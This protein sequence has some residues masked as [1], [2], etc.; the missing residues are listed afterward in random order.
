MENPKYA[1]VI[2]RFQIPPSFH[3]APKFF[4]QFPK[5]RKEDE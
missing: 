3:Y 5:R 4:N 2:F 1:E